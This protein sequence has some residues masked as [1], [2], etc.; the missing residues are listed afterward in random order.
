MDGEGTVAVLLPIIWVPVPPTM[1]GK[2]L[3]PTKG[4]MATSVM[5]PSAGIA[6]RS[7]LLSST[8]RERPILRRLAQ[9]HLRV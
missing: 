9:Q 2:T 6:Q 1:S 4:M 5:L 7:D 3:E 8:R